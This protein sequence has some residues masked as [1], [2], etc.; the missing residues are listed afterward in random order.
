MIKRAFDATTQYV[1]APMS[2]YL[3]KYYRS[4]F[5]ALNVH[6]RKE[7]VATETL[8][9]DN[10]AAASGTTQAQLCCGQQSPV[11]DIF[12]I[13]TDKQFVDILEDTIRQRGAMD[14]L[15]IDSAQV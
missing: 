3:Q 12:E 10:P 13:K 11:Y 7:A 14:K 9:S 8:Y 4:P 2:T 5:P 1:H 6:R 15:I